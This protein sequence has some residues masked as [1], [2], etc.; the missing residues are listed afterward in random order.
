MPFVVSGTKLLFRETLPQDVVDK[1]N[2]T[3]GVFRA[4]GKPEA[5]STISFEDGDVTAAVDET[6]GKIEEINFKLGAPKAEGALLPE[7]IVLDGNVEATIV[8]KDANDNVVTGETAVAPLSQYTYEATLKA[9]A[10]TEATFADT[11]KVTTQK[12]GAGVN[13]PNFA[14][15]GA[16][17]KE[18]GTVVTAPTPIEAITVN[19]SGKLSA[20]A[21][22]SFEIPIS[23]DYKWELSE[24]SPA[25]ESIMANKTYTWTVTITSREA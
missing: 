22:P 20:N 16:E 10:N 9:A 5:V 18:D 1:A 3:P 19:V 4:S 25:D 24:K 13:V 11:V 14:E 12:G 2:N 21:V 7:T 6:T 15:D 23:P 8:W 17:V